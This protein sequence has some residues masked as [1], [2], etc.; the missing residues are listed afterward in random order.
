MTAPAELT[1]GG[2]PAPPA[3]RPASLRARLLRGNVPYV[4][5]LPA[6]AVLALFLVV[7]M[8]KVILTSLTPSTAVP[9]S[10]NNYTRVLSNSFYQ[11]ILARTI[12]TGLLTAVIA[13]VIAY[14]LS[15]YITFSS[16]RIKRYVTLLV[17]TPLLISVVVKGYALSLLLGPASPVNRVFPQ[18]G[19]N[20]VF[21]QWGVLLGFVYAFLPYMV[22]S[23][24]AALAG[25]DPRTISAARSLGAGFGYV[26]RKIVLP[27]SLP[28]IISGCVLVFSLSM[29]SV[30]LALVLGG[31]GYQLWLFLLYQQILTVFDWPTGFTMG[32]I[33]LVLIIAIFL[34]GQLLLRARWRRSR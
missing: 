14:P 16:D 6:V 32:I 4:L 10:G 2:R 23:I 17:L 21:T 7:P 31:S 27:P 5:S 8:V 30:A 25:L 20:L 13:L 11:E 9:N 24:N 26:L 3:G 33:F 19:L 18:A 28:G 1:D 34:I 29:S 12:L 22:L 15:L